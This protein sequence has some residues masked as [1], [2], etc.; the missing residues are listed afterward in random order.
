MGA[1][2][3]A[4]PTASA[5]TTNG[6]VLFMGA[7]EP[8]LWRC[9][10]C[11]GGVASAGGG[12]GGG[13]GSTEAELSAIS[14]CRIRRERFESGRSLFWVVFVAEVRVVP[15]AWFPMTARENVVRGTRSDRP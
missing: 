10:G 13:G 5:L 11:C 1:A 4:V 12:G 6:T 9:R 3:V 14:C 15:E 8:R 7:E 2:S